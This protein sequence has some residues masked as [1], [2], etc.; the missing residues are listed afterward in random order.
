MVQQ[1]INLLAE[2]NI[3]KVIYIILAIV[4]LI[5]TLEKFLVFWYFKKNKLNKK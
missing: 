1:L 2:I 4:L 3:F 5:K